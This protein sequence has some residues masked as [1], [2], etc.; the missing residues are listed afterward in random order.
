MTR[1]QAVRNKARGKEFERE[2][3]ELAVA[4]GFT[5]KRA[6][7]SNGEALG[8]TSDVDAV[9]KYRE[10]QEFRIQ[11]KR[12]MRLPAYL[13]VPVGCDMVVF[14]QDR[15]EPYVMLPYQK[16]L[17]LLACIPSMRSIK[18]E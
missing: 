14:K 6:W 13:Q 11:A 17:D 15:K 12:R 2:L 16:L 9:L 3:V 1:H 4:R 8:H 5:A 7:G 10:G 18:D